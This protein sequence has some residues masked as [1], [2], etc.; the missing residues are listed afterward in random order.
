MQPRIRRLVSHYKL[1]SE[2]RLKQCQYCSSTIR[3]LHSSL[4]NESN[5]SRCI[6]RFPKK[7]KLWR[8]FLFML[9]WNHKVMPSMNDM[10][11]LRLFKF[12]GTLEC[13]ESGYQMRLILDCKPNPS[14]R[15][16]LID[17][18][19]TWATD[20]VICQ[21]SKNDSDGMDLTMRVE[22]FVLTKYFVFRFMNRK[23]RCCSSARC[24]L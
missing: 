10:S 21:K 18:G 20:G 6:I 15:S 8:S 12:Q 7:R 19:L 4:L 2:S 9:I 3:S 1:I 11:P 5:D 16:K 17:C 13:L 23:G 24:G 14:S 22:I